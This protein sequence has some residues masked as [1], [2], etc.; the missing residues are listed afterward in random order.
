MR[1]ASKVDWK[2]I[3]YNPMSQGTR[4]HQTASYIV[5]DSPF[6]MLADSPSLYRKN[7]DWVDFVTP[8]PTVFDATD[9][10]DGTLGEYIVTMR[11]KDGKYYVGGL[12]NWDAR[13][14]DLS[15]SFLPEGKY[16]ATILTDGVNAAKE[17]DDYKISTSTVDKDSKMKVRMISA[18]ASPSA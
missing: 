15:F 8:I 12:T 7:Q 3:Y 5:V 1:N 10:I 16:T 9:V 2:A 13:D 11:E 17:A 14:Y 18:A 6:T 4:A